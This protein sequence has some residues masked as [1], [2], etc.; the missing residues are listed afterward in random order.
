MKNYFYFIVLLSI[1]IFWGQ[2]VMADSQDSSIIVQPSK[3]EI[4]A[5]PGQ[6]ISKTFLI[7]N[8]SNF[9]V[10]YK[11]IEK[12]FRQSS[13]DGKL[14]FYDSITEKASDWLVP[15]YLQISLKPLESKEIG[16][17][18]SVPENFPG[19][20]HYGSI[21]FQPVNQSV[22][23]SQNN[24]GALIMLTVTDGNTKSTAIGNIMSFSA[25]GLNQGNNV[26]FSFNIQN[27]GNTHF[28]ALGKLAIWNIF[29]Q[30]VGDYDAGQ[31]TVFPGTS[32]IFKWQWG[33]APKFGIYKAEILLADDPKTLNYKSVQSAWFIIL[34][35]QL[36]LLII[37]AVLTVY[38]I[39]KNL[40]KS[41]NAY[42]FNE[43][44]IIKK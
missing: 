34:P 3:I 13:T 38:L 17:V 21:I 39:L 24:F 6:K 4:T 42:N 10:S 14:E 41:R 5:S 8:R 22:N 18:I 44:L 9:Y 23:N 40:K 31:L 43:M 1:S 26:K 36:S 29:G 35:W 30:K 2:H 32:R 16:L 20:G 15:Q 27:T 7:I 25:G 33:D 11:V 12:S 37:F 19:G 28:D